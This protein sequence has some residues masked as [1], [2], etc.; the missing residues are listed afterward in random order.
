VI[1]PG[2]VAFIYW[3][4]VLASDVLALASKLYT[5]H[6]LSA[7]DS[8]TIKC[9]VT[10]GV[11]YVPIPTGAGQNFAGLF[12]VDLPMT[13]VTGQEFNIVVRRIGNT[14]DDIYTKPT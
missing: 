11:T 8:H 4:Q 3:P 12:T 5:S 6:A 2:S 1:P 7:A 10:G 13:V 9:K 14:F